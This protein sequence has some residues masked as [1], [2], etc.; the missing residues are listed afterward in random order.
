MTR[1]QTHRLR[2]KDSVFDGVVGIILLLL[3]DLGFRHSDEVAVRQHLQAVGLPRIVE[4]A[5]HLNDTL[6][7]EL[8]TMDLTPMLI[9]AGKRFDP[10]NMDDD[11]PDET[12]ISA[13][14]RSRR[15]A[16]TVHMGLKRVTGEG[17]IEVLLKPKVVLESTMQ[18]IDS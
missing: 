2:D 13:A 5:L 16:G 8:T 18:G 12:E 9:P 4:M 15:I 17:G 14:L 11:Y 6:G 3:S 1:A 10:D 7:V